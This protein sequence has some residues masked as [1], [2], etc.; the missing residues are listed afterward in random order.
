MA[1]IC[2]RI[3]FLTIQLKIVSVKVPEYS[4]TGNMFVLKN[5]GEKLTAMTKKKGEKILNFKNLK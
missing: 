5:I 2:F 1:K 3:L 4:K